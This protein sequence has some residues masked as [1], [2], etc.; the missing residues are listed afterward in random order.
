MTSPSRRDA[1]QTAAEIRQAVAELGGLVGL[2]KVSDP[3]LRSRFYEE[4]GVTGSYDPRTRSV[5][6]S[7][8]LGVR[9]DRVGGAITPLRTRIELG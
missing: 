3:K 6:A 2:L 8:D 1:L 4:A 7:A 9:K 5:E